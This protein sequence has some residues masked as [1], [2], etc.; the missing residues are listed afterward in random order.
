MARLMRLSCE[1][2]T[3]ASLL[4]IDEV[5]STEIR[6]QFASMYYILQQLQGTAIH[7]GV[8]TARTRGCCLGLPGPRG[9]PLTIRS[10][11]GRSSMC[12]CLDT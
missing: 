9:F 6:K 1:A 7:I 8:D 2:N 5:P 4:D 11:A 3:S 10:Q 12:L